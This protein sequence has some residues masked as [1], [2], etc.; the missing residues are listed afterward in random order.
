MKILVASDNHG[1]QYCLEELL[2]I[3]RD[4]ID[5]WLHCGDSEFISSNDL[6]DSFKTV[7]GNMDYSNEFP[8]HL[9]E[10][11]DGETFVVVHGHKHQVKFTFDPLYELAVENNARVVFYGHTH[12]ARVDKM[13]DVY[14]INPGSIKFPRGPIPVGS[15]AIYEQEDDKEKITYFDWNHNEIEELSQDLN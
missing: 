1:D 11:F 5:L 8:N 12:I 15:Y 6:W 4:E 9:V 10:T 14:F 13:K 3:Y 7:S 2:D